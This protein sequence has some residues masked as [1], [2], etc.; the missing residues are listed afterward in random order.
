MRPTHHP[1]LCCCSQSDAFLG[2]RSVEGF[3]I[4]LIRSEEHFQSYCNKIFA[5][6]D[7]CIT[8]RSMAEL[9]HS[10]LRYELRV[11]AAGLPWGGTSVLGRDL[12]GQVGSG[13]AVCRF[14]GIAGPSLSQHTSLL[15]FL[16]ALYSKQLIGLITFN[17]NM[18]ARNLGLGREVGH[19]WGQS[20]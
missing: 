4:N 8:N 11:S 14:H 19:T 9:K 2:A 7:F 10:S 6:W 15:Q 18:G 16:R 17:P 1:I 13:E 20:R 3:K 12:T 5:G